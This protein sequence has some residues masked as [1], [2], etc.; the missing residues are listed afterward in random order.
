MPVRLNQVSTSRKGARDSRM[1][2]SLDITNDIESHLEA[3]AR[4]KRWGHFKEA[5][6]YIA[7]NLEHHL[8]LPLVLLEYCDLLVKRGSHNEFS[9]FVSSR[10]WDSDQKTKCLHI[11]DGEMGPDLYELHYDLLRL[12]ARIQFVSASTDDLEVLQTLFFCNYLDKRATSRQGQHVPHGVGI[13]FDSTEGTINTD[14]LDIFNPSVI[15]ELIVYLFS[16]SKS[17]AITSRS[18]KI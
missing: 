1:R 14:A 15:T 9:S 16:R 11:S 2:F 7:A 3:V 4:L 8:S 10:R 17:F 5:K 12:R 6:Q 13:P 18:S